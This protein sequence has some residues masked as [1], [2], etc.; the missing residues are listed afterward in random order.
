MIILC[1]LKFK[2][3][4]I[5]IIVIG[6]VT[7][8]NG[9][10]GVCAE[11]GLKAHQANFDEATDLLRQTIDREVGDDCVENKKFIECGKTACADVESIGACKTADDLKETLSKVLSYVENISNDCYNYRLVTHDGSVASRIRSTNTLPG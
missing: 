11:Y 6:L 9:D 1:C 10:D 5:L 3:K 7:I 4:A 8:C 2:M